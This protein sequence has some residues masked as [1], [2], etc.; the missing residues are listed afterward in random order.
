LEVKKMTD[1]IKTSTPMPIPGLEEA[2]EITRILRQAGFPEREIPQKLL[3]LDV[4][5]RGELVEEILAKMDEKQLAE[6]DKFLENNPTPDE[7]ADFLKLDK[8]EMAKRLKAK[9]A[10]IRD[11]YKDELQKVKK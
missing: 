1:Q 5:V 9:V 10:E 11:Q 7:T 8:I 4:I 3:E 6:Y 2:Q